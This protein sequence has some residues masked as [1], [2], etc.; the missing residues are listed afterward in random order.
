LRDGRVT[1][2]VSTGD[3]AAALD[4]VQY[5]TGLGPCTIAMHSNDPVVVRRLG[6]HSDWPDLAA[7]ARAG[8][9]GAV[10]AFALAVKR[11][12]RWAPLG[13]LSLY[14]DEPQGFTELE[15]D[16][17]SILAAYAAVAAAAARGGDELARREAA[18]HR[19]LST[20]DV[21]GQAKGILME[22][23]HL[24]AGAAFDVLREVSQSL[25]VKLS[26]LASRIAETGEIPR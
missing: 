12:G 8:G 14:S 26:E 9:V 6:E 2:S 17:G 16:F 20:R 5:E 18:L 24:S 3:S 13:V 23:R 4:T 21:I 7:S 15:L 10:A 22:R 1:M 11:N 19:S 25:N